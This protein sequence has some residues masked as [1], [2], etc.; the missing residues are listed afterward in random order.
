MNTYFV[1]AA[2]LIIVVGLAHSILGEM[3]IFSRM[4]QGRWVPTNGGSVLHQPHVRILWASWHILTIFGWSFAAI[5]FL[6]AS[7]S[8]AGTPRVAVLQSVAVATLLASVLVFYA[9]KARHPGWLGLLGVAALIW[10][11]IG[12]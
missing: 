12:R 10:V 7:E 3:L 11:G 6:V 8:S 1:G 5:L 4:R 2:I 9:T